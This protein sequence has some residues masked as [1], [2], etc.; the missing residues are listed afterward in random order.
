MGQRPFRSRQP[1]PGGVEAER[2]SLMISA[3][4]R[5]A[6]YTEAIAQ[7]KGHISWPQLSAEQQQE[8]V[9]PLESFAQPPSETAPIPQLRADTDACDG[10][11]K[12]AVEAMMRIVDGNHLVRIPV[13]VL[14]QT[15][16]EN[17]EQLDS[18][19]PPG[20]HRPPDR[21]RK[22]VLIW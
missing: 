20:T 10:R 2:I 11:L 13:S 18:G 12:K 14:F 7:V 16:I 8:V 6:A 19:R 1:V 17:E 22:K 21:P 4:A 3:A 9:S 5:I 15:G